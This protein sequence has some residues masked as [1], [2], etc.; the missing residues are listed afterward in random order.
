M[1]KSKVSYSNDFA[2]EWTDYNEN[3]GISFYEKYNKDKL[4]HEQKVSDYDS[5]LRK[6]N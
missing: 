5:G 3:G 4:S 6:M 2:M 1:E